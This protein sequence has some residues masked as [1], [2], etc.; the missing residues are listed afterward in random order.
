VCFSRQT[1]NG[2]SVDIPLLTLLPRLLYQVFLGLFFVQ[3][4]PDSYKRERGL[5]LSNACSSFQSLPR[6]VISMTVSAKI[7][8]CGQAEPITYGFHHRK[9][10]DR[11]MMWLA[12]QTRRQDYG[13]S[14]TKSPSLYPLEALSSK[15]QTVG[16]EHVPQQ[17]LPLQTCSTSSNQ[18]LFIWALDSNHLSLHCNATNILLPLTQQLESPN[19]G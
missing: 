18:L 17:L 19:V 15:W 3:D 9:I 14:R 7:A 1:L 2:T 4:K 6:A 11:F 5:S 10:T 13:E 16:L 12:L 8:D